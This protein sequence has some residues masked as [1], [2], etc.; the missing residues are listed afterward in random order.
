MGDLSRAGIL[1]CER[2]VENEKQRI[3]NVNKERIVF[4]V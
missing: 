2:V 4:F 1:L 3:I